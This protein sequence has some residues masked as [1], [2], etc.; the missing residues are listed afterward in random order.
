MVLFG[1]SFVIGC[2]SGES[3]TGAGGSTSSSTAS[4][5]STSASGTGGG[6][7][8]DCN[9]CVEVKVAFDADGTPCHDAASACQ[10]DPTCGTWL[11]CTNTCFQHDFTDGC[12]AACDAAGAGAKSLYDPLYAC[13][14]S[15]CSSECALVKCD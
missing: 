5:G 1:V 7:N 2:G 11:Q 12:F 8:K 9:T 6:A 13:V 10:G 3:S 14:C 15:S 4:T